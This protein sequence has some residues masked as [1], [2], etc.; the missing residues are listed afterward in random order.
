MAF[1]AG[2]VAAVVKELNTALDGAK[3]EKV[4]QPDKD[5]VILQLH[6]DREKGASKTGGRLLIDAGSNNPRIGF[7]ERALENPPAPPMFC[8]LLRKH[9]IGARIT[10]V[11]QLGFERAV[12]ISL[13]ARDEMGFTRTKYLICETMGRCSNLIFLGSDYRIIASLKI[14]LSIPVVIRILR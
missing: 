2:F 3:I 12:E 9:L 5:A 10:G 4:Q 6:L 8:M 14:S 11:R 7:T 13:D 1:D